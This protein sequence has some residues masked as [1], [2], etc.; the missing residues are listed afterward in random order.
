MKRYTTKNIA[1]YIGMLLVLLILIVA[2]LF[3]LKGIGGTSDGGLRVKVNGQNVGNGSE[4]T[5]KI[6]EPIEFTVENFLGGKV[7]DY[8][9]AIVPDV[10]NGRDFDVIVGQ[11]SYKFSELKDLSKGFDINVDSNKFTLKNTNNI[12]YILSTIIGQAVILS[13][14][15]DFSALPYMKIIITSGS[16]TVSYP[17]KFGGYPERIEFDKELIIF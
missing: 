5:L 2:I 4:I 13:Q 17:L 1:S 8:T 10:P 3:V 9:V 6:N 16:D 15:V 14:D 11:D 12:E 7:E